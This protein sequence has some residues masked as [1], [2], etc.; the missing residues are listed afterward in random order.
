MSTTTFP[1]DLSRLLAF[2]R[3]VEAGSF[4]EAARRAG[5]TT[6]A[7]S[8]AVARFEKA[9]GLRL[10]HRST[11]SLALTE[12]GDR[13]MTAGRALVESLARVQS[14]LGDVARDDGGRVRVTAPASFARACI[15]PRLP[16]FL[17]ERPEIEIEV[18]FRNEI[19]DLAAEGVDIAIRSGPL[20]RA[21][22]H[23]ARR[24]CTFSWIACASP[25]YLKARGVPVTPYEL[26]A[27]DHVG[28]RNPATGQILTWRFADP[29]GKGPIRV[30][31]KPKHICD[32]AH[33]TLDL[34]TSGFGIGWGPAWLVTEDL[35]A[36]RLVEV[37]ESWRVPGEPLWMVRTSG[38]RPP[39]RTQRVMSFLNTLPA[40]FSDKAA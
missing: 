2:V 38:R 37:L 18:K 1:P 9:H 13:L 29:R 24:L 35:R 22:G 6:S 23:Q 8:K 32:D 12:E 26:A 15:L 30:T 40:A 16:A 4:A 19:L 25:V 7:M 39:L 34:I 17:R 21:P 27:H 10:L 31:P 33:A 28:F 14:A 3:V 11:H 36:G 20:D 5:T